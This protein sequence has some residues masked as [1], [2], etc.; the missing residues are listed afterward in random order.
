MK[1]KQETKIQ[2]IFAKLTDIVVLVLFI[3]MTFL[4]SVF[5][6]K[7]FIYNRFAPGTEIGGVDVSKE[8]PS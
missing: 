1:D 2:I 8:T 7:T 6:L 3:A 4:I 5:L